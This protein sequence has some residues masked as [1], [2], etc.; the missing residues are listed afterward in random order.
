MSKDEKSI[1]MKDCYNFRTYLAEDEEMNVYLREINSYPQLD[2]EQEKE[3]SSFCLEKKF[4]KKKT[5]I[6]KAVGNKI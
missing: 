6:N 3:R 5:E 4:T 2:Y 1:K